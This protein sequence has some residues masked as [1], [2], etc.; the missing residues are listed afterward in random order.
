MQIN[1][2]KIIP[3]LY[4]VAGVSI[5]GGI[6]ILCLLTGRAASSFTKVLTVMLGVLSI[7]LGGVVLFVVYTSR[8]N[9]PNF[10]LYDSKA[11]K[12]IPVEELTFE[13]V[14]SR[15]GYY[16]SLISD[17]QVQTWKKNMLSREND[18][19]GPNDVYK[20]LV[21]YK[22]L[23]DLNELDRPETWMLFNEAPP[24][25][26]TGLID[27]L[28]LGGE[29]EMCQTLRF[30]YEKTESNDDIEHIRDFVMGNAKYLRG[31]IMRYVSNNIEWFY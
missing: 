21:A 4:A 14:N 3:I 22:M 26:I 13:K 8:D 28:R 23:C 2:K 5:V 19:F 7:L 24:E 27:A 29:S 6:L 10:F 20:P 1:V 31:R 30:F 25:V 15:M 16:M 9:D 11:K 12:N 18:R 17:S